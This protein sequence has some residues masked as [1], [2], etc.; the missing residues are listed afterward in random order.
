MQ[1]DKISLASSNIVVNAQPATTKQHQLQ[2]Q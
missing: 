2:E 1:Q